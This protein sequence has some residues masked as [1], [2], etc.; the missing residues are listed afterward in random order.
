MSKEKFQNFLKENIKKSAFEY[1]IAKKDLF[2]SDIEKLIQFYIVLRE[3]YG[4]RTALTR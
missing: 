2:S 4:K 1:L 3:K